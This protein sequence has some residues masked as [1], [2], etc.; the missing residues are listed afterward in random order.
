MCFLFCFLSF[1]TI[2]FNC[3]SNNTAALHL[4]HRFHTSP[5]FITLCCD[6]MAIYCGER[7]GGADSP[8]P[9]LHVNISSRTSLH[10]VSPQM[11]CI[12]Y[13]LLNTYRSLLFSRSTSKS[14]LL[15]SYLPSL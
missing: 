12:L 8:I 3:I 5:K 14:L 7:G 1:E 4:T 15:L 13:I 10:F 2:L 9:T 11:N 6:V